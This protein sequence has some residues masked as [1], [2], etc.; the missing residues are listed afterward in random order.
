MYLIINVPPIAATKKLHT[1]IY[2]INCTFHSIHS[3]DEV[4]CN[5]PFEYRYRRICSSNFSSKIL[6]LPYNDLSSF[7]F[8]LQYVIF[9]KMFSSFVDF[10]SFYFNENYIII[11]HPSTKNLK[12][13][14]TDSY[15]IRPI[16]S[17]EIM[18]DSIYQESA[19]DE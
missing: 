11:G 18:A 14:L 9:M 3:N 6:T 15:G 7:H 12:F 19:V 10:I 17:R 4:L 8:E 1:Y 13:N 5:N 16:G 2:G